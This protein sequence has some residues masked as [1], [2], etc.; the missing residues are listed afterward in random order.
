MNRFSTAR[1]LP[2]LLASYALV[3]CASVDPGAQ[4]EPS[5]SDLEKTELIEGIHAGE[6]VPYSATTDSL[7]GVV[8]INSCTG[9][10]IGKYHLISA[11]HCFARDGKQTVNLWGYSISGGWNRIIQF[12]GSDLPAR[13]TFY[14]G[15]DGSGISTDFAIVALDNDVE[16]ANRRLGDEYFNR[17][18]LYA[19]ATKVGKKLHIVGVGV[20]AYAGTGFNVLRRGNGGR[21]VSIDRH[22]DGYFVAEADGPRICEGDSG[23]PAIDRVDGHHPVIWGVLSLYNSW[24]WNNTPCSW[25]GDDMFWSKTTTKL[26]FIEDVMKTHSRLGSSFRCSRASN[27]TVGDYA[28]CW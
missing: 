6:L 10:F 23:G 11:A 2:A 24:P 1:C 21:R 7:S 26:T 25:D 5:E 22:Q 15:W 20:N 28:R 4:A 9:A 16:F 17:Y 13:V 19:G 12:N 14:P 18:R 8:R 3:A 27:E